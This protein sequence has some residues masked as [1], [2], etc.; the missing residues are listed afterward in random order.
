MN[1]SFSKLVTEAMN[2]KTPSGPVKAV[3]PTDASWALSHWMKIREGARPR[4]VEHP[5]WG[6]GTVTEISERQV[7]IEWD[8]LQSWSRHPGVVGLSEARKI[9]VTE[10]GKYPNERDLSEEHNMAGKNSKKMRTRRGLAEDSYTG[11]PDPSDTILTGTDNMSVKNSSTPLS[12]MD[13]DGG[14][15]P[16]PREETS[17]GK[18]GPKQP[19]VDSMDEPTRK[20]KMSG[21]GSQKKNSEPKSEAPK[22]G[23]KS[24]SKGA[25]P[26]AKKSDDSSEPKGEKKKEKPEDVEED[27]G[28]ISDLDFEGHLNEVE[29]VDAM[30]F[31]LDECGCDDEDGD[32]EPE[33]DSKKN[34]KKPKQMEHNLDAGEIAVTQDFLTKMLKAVSE[35]DLGEEQFALIAQATA[36]CCSEDR[37]LDVA[38]IGKVMSKLKELAGAGDAEDEDDADEA[39]SPGDGEPAGDEAG[40][41][42]EGETK[43]MASKDVEK[44]EEAWMM[45]VPTIRNSYRLDTSGM[46]AEEAELAE[47]MRLSGV[48]M[49]AIRKGVKL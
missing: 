19:P 22:G 24:G 29:A 43:L 13:G 34:M 32:E 7:R 5:S 36:E 21:G 17:R 2:E 38:D 4:R 47:I 42:H 40:D 1:K 6:P 46:S 16:K 26:F 37:T 9:V 18:D 8:R 3:T 41:E 12:G 31:E 10:L 14:A 49:P 45:A 11:V 25:N 35:I 44:L 15:F 28:S 27:F 30:H 20:V 33:M 23:S 48:K 39:Y